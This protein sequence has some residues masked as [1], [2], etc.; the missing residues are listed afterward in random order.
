M[1][2]L[3]TQM[4]GDFSTSKQICKQGIT[5]QGCR[6]M[7]KQANYVM[8]VQRPLNPA[9]P[10]RKSGS[11]SPSSLLMF[12]SHGLVSETFHACNGNSSQ[13]LKCMISSS[14]LIIIHFCFWEAPHHDTSTLMALRH[15]NLLLFSGSPVSRTR[16]SG[17]FLFAWLC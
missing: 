2:I 13:L 8:F 16:S 14:P 5:I 15:R 3:K 12:F 9:I 17:A 11:T 1:I 6:W 4:W 7:N 10:S